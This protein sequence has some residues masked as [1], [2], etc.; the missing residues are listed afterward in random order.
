MII[1]DITER[2][3]E[4]P[5]SNCSALYQKKNSTMFYNIDDKRG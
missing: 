1:T 2:E 3:R 5:N 4:F